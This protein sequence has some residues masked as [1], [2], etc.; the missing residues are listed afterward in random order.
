VG[1]SPG[2][3][4]PFLFLFLLEANLSLLCYVCRHWCLV[5]LPLREEGIKA[6]GDMAH[7]VELLSDMLE[8]LG[9]IS[10]TT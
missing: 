4:T 7:L 8:A 3:G 9:S 10:N 1:T 6:H 5:G 2:W